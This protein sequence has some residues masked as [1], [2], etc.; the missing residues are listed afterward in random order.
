VATS[1]ECGFND[2]AAAICIAGDDGDD[3]DAAALCITGNGAKP[4]RG[5]IAV[6]RQ[7]SGTP[8]AAVGSRFSRRGAAAEHLPTSLD[9]RALFGA[10]ATHSSHSNLVTVDLFG[11]DLFSFFWAASFLS[12]WTCSVGD[13]LA[14]GLEMLLL[15]CVWLALD[16]GGSAGASTIQKESINSRKR[17]NAM[18]PNRVRWISDDRL[19]EANNVQWTANGRVA[20]QNRC[21]VKSI[22]SSKSDKYFCCEFPTKSLEAPIS[23]YRAFL[24]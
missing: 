5:S 24:R 18:D 4:W 3:G 23:F 15:S 22:F 8:T 7:A 9:P 19:E 13:D 2:G 20:H 16:D 14:L 1:S 6:G 11:R 21:F 17:P 10:A 12:F